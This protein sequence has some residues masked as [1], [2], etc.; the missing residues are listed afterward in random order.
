M[1][2][3]RTLFCTNDGSAV[4][5][6]QQAQL[7]KEIAEYDADALL[8]TGLETLLDYFEHA[9][10][11]DVP[12]LHHDGIEVT[13]E[14]V[15][16]EEAGRFGPL[17]RV[18]TAFVY[19][20]PYSGSAGFFDIQP[21][22][23][24]FNPPH[25]FV[26][27]QELQVILQRW[28]GAD[29]ASV[30]DEFKR[31]LGDVQSHLERL[32]GDFAAF[33]GNLRELARARVEA[34]RAKLLADR[35]TVASLGYP[36]RQR[37]GAPKTYAV[38]IQRRKAVTRPR[39][40]GTPFKPEAEFEK[41]NY[42]RA[43]EIIANMA[44]VMEQSPS[45]FAKFEETD[46]R[47]EFLMQLNGQFEGD[48][49]GETFRAAGKIDIIINV[50]GRAIFIAEAKFYDGPKSVSDAIDQLLSYTTWRDTKLALLIFSRRKDFTAVL[51][52]IDDAVQ[53]HSSTRRKLA[54]SSESAFRYT[55]AR[56]D[57]PE[58]EM[59]LTVLAF[60]VPTAD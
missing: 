8:T 10:E 58:R 53:Q 46:L 29:H 50:D 34:R 45:T 24:G 37:P 52:T 33:N 14:E 48:A 59:T 18:G 20:V 36:V 13:E 4:A 15:A 40:S 2:Q 35:A 55:L 19:H 28:G 12:V 25:G 26:A 27:D 3:E 11:L 56:K 9:Y 60:T 41:E 49:T 22:T 39:P 6:S 1:R 47:N 5:R 43:L 54:Y 21:S 57:D 31:R 17:R 51:R 30:G 32:R 7:E 42:E 16:T 23:F 38:P 44:K